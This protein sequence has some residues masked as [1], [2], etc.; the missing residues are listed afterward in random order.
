MI[1][2]AVVMG[3]VAAA[4]PTILSIDEATLVAELEANDPRVAIAAAKVTAARADIAVARL[5]PNPSISIEREEP[6]VNG[7]AMPT[8]YLRL[9]VPFDISGRRGLLLDAA[10]AAVRA[11]TSDAAQNK[12]EL[13]VA[14]LRVFDDCARARLQVEILTSSRA[15]LVRSVEIARERGKAGDASGY[16]IQ[17]FELELAGHDDD[18]ASAQIDL[19]R[20]RTQLATLTGRTGE[21]DASTTLELPTA[22]PTLELLL[23]KASDRG[24]VRAAKLRSEAA[25]RRAGAADRGWVPLPTLTGGAMTADLGAQTGTGYVAG[26]ALTI[27][28]FDRGQGDKARASADLHLADAEG[29]LLGRQ[30]PGAVEVAHR[31][32][33]ARI[34]QARK[35]ATEQLGRLDV[36]VLASE[37]AFREGNASVVEL[38]DAHRAARGVRLRALD[39]RH[40]V[41]R[42]KRELELAVGQRL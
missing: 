39:L 4:Q 26:I 16:E 18:L 27:P 40:Q 20:V 37:T 13:L 14:A 5:R 21:L 32:L 1:V 9:N 36:I 23:A 28:L 6:F 35:L 11:A 2:A 25:R 29:D 15:M 31:T 10:A 38:L 30:V 19:V 3:R 8:N 41:A 22:V 42:D 24:D 7:T 12:H 33:V 17:R 34:E